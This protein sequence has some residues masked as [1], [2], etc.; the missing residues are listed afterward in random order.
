MP[1][2]LT[3]IL[4]LEAAIQF[5]VPMVLGANIGTTVTNTIVAFG[6][7]RGMTMNEFKETIPGVIVDDV[8]EALTITIFFALELSFGLIS[9]LVLS[10]GDFYTNVLQLEGFFSAFEN[11]IIDCL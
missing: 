7:E 1:A 5:G 9:K 10:L 2:L 8:Y 11:N 3:T 6:V 4:P